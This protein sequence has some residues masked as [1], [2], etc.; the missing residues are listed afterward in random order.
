MT[1]AQE[2]P[3]HDAVRIEL[4]RMV[5]LAADVP[6]FE[7]TGCTVVHDDHT[8]THAAAAGT[9]ASSCSCGWTGT[10]GFL[11]GARDAAM[12]LALA[13]G[14]SHLRSLRFRGVL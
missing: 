3:L 4:D 5:A 8:V 10:T 1:P 6:E 13:A 11:R 2:A 14:E 7:L 12:G 9:I